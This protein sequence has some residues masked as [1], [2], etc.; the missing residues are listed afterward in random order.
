MNSIHA[1]C[2]FWCLGTDNSNS[3]S[4]CLPWTN[5]A[6]TCALFFWGGV[7]LKVLWTNSFVPFRDL[8]RLENCV[9]D[10]S[11]LCLQSSSKQSISVLTYGIARTNRG[12]CSSTKRKNS[13]IAFGQC[14]NDNL[15][16]LA[17]FMDDLNR[18]FHAT[19]GYS[20]KKGRIPMVCW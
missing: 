8:K 2:G 19:L 11:K 16:I 20:E 13:F 12:Y 6:S 9:K 17:S 10:N 3:P 14:V 1:V 7:D 5:G 4:R 15:S 18:D